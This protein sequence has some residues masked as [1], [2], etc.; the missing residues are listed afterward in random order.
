MKKETVNLWPSKTCWRHSVFP[1][2]LQQLNFPHSSLAFGVRPLPLI[3]KLRRE[4]P[5]CQKTFSPS[6]LWSSLSQLKTHMMM[7]FICVHPHALG[8]LGL[9]LTATLPLGAVPSTSQAMHLWWFAHMC[10]AGM[11]QNWDFNPNLKVPKCVCLPPNG[12]N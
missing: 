4:D 6:N 11:Q 5:L 3:L 1:E 10:I 7:L 2:T 8:A 9:P 12:D